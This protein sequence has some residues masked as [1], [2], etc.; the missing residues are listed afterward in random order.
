LYQYKNTDFSPNIIFVI[1]LIFIA[2]VL[3]YICASVIN[4][5]KI[6]WTYLKG[7]I[8]CQAVFTDLFFKTNWIILLLY[9]F[10]ITKIYSQNI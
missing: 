1:N 9:A 4:T 7:N 8:K 6:N 2:D 5:L 10:S 3:L